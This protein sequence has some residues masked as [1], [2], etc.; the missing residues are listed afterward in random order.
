MSRKSVISLTMSVVVVIVGAC[1]M[2]TEGDQTTATPRAD[3]QG[4][5]AVFVTDFGI[6]LVGGW[7]AGAADVDDAMAVALARTSDKIDI[8]GLVVT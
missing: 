4:R 3:G 7:R 2:G 8:L 1:G 5:P 6:G